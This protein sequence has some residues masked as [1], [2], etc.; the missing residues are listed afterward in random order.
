[1]LWLYGLLIGMG[2]DANFVPSTTPTTGCIWCSG[3]A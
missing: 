1:V 3:S 2:D